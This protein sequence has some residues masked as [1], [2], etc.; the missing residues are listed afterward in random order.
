VESEEKEYISLRDIW[1][2]AGLGC[3]NGWIL[4]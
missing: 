3:G 1:E 4:E 2:L